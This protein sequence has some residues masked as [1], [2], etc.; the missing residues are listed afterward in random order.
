MHQ[1]QQWDCSRKQTKPC[2]TFFL[3]KNCKNCIQKW[4]L[5]VIFSRRCSTCP[6]NKIVYNFL[7]TNPNGMNQSFTCRQKYNLWRKK[8]K[9]FSPKFSIFFGYPFSLVL[10]LFLGLFGRNF[11]SR[12]PIRRKLY[13]HQAN[14]FFLSLIFFKWQNFNL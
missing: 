5:Q 4:I 8:I 2:G 10:N 1:S 11:C 6:R 9:C 3:L 12:A 13:S 7:I 14:Q